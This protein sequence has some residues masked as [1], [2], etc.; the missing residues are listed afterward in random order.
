MRCAS[1]LVTSST[2]YR[3][4]DCP[5]SSSI[6]CIPIQNSSRPV[7]ARIVARIVARDATRATRGCDTHC[8]SAVPRRLDAFVR[9]T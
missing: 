1:T 8:F 4:N 9:R 2:V 3:E 7:T 5:Y 6:S